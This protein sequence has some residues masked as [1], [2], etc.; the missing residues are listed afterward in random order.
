[1]FLVMFILGS[2]WYLVYLL[3]GQRWVEI[4]TQNTDGSYSNL[5]RASPLIE[6]LVILYNA[7]VEVALIYV[8]F[9]AIPYLLGLIKPEQIKNEQ[10]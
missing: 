6:L 5:V 7:S 1:M 2:A 4:G 9:L 8:P 10:K 3:S